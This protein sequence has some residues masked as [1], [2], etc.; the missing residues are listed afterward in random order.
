MLYIQLNTFKHHQV[1]DSSRG[2][3]LRDV[4]PVLTALEL[5]LV[6]VKPIEFEPCSF[7]GGALQSS[8]PTQRRQRQR[9]M[10]TT[11]SA[12]GHTLCLRPSH[13]QE[14]QKT[15]AWLNQH[16][17]MLSILVKAWRHFSRQVHMA[18]IKVKILCHQ[19]SGFFTPDKR[20]S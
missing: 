7:L 14:Y 17:V 15:L 12:A 1:T 4:T 6:G 5:R 18:C 16:D 11:Q 8:G 3:R 13:G 10:P 9:T 2:S 20:R 19:V